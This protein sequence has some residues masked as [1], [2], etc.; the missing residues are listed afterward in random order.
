MREEVTRD[1]MH[2]VLKESFQV[3]AIYSE[4]GM[5]ELFSQAYTD[6]GNVFRPGPSMKILG[7]GITD[8]LEILSTGEQVALNIIDLHNID[9]CSFIGTEDLGKINEDGTFEVLGR[10]DNS[11]MRGCNLIMHG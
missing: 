4:Y 11:D 5:T 8:P 6:G 2:S 10:M 7:R 3:D 1:E 9:S